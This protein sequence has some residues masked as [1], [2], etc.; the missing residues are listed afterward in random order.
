MAPCINCPHVGKQEH[1]VAIDPVTGHDVLAK[2]IH[3][4]RVVLVDHSA[5]SCR[6]GDLGKQYLRDM[7]DN[8]HDEEPLCTKATVCKP[9]C[10]NT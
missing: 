7:Y 2:H 3:V 1:G 9:L 10:A 4:D 6:R 8:D 5:S